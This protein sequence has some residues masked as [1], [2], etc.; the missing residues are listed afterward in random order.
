M[1]GVGDSLLPTLVKPDQA[2]ANSFIILIQMSVG[3]VTTYNYSDNMSQHATFLNL[4]KI[5]FSVLLKFVTR[6]ILV[7]RLQS[8]LIRRYSVIAPLPLKVEVR[9]GFL[10]FCT[11]KMFKYFDFL[12][13]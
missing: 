10:P 11:R 12:F 2:K 8:V 6:T 7:I 5:F 13:F 9:V 3:I 4:D 1:E